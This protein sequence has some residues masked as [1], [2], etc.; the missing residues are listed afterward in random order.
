[1]PPPPSP[2]PP[3]NA[4][5]TTSQS[6]PA[7]AGANTKPSA[8]ITQALINPVDNE[9]PDASA[10]LG[11]ELNASTAVSPDVTTATPAGNNA[12]SNAAADTVANANT[13]AAPKPRLT[14]STDARAT[15]EFTVQA[16]TN[17]H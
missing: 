16:N 3:R 4:P 7:L 1:T 8:T 17:N 5:A 11:P 2:P 10:T 14:A 13:P 12:N 6:P 9:D 15:A